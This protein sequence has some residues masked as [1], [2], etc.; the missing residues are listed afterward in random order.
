[1]VIFHIHVSLGSVLMECLYL[2][3]DHEKWRALLYAISFLHSIVQERRKFGPIGWCVPYEFNNS[4]L[5]ASL[6]FLE[7]HLSS[8]IMVGTPLSWNTIQYMVAEVQ[9]PDADS[10][11]F[12][13]IS[14]RSLCLRGGSSVAFLVNFP[15]E[16][17]Y[18]FLQSSN[19]SVRFATSKV[20][21]TD[22][23]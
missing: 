11:R 19:W 8:T 17:F 1:M 16:P 23:R 4:D 5:D 2:Q 15:G 7:K 13:A 3:V 10:V 21:R 20:R 18:G 22:Y 12:V 9:S 14:W 6:L